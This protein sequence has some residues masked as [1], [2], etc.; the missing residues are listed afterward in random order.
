MADSKMKISIWSDV[1]CPFCYIG[2]RHYEAALAAFPD[3]DFIETEWHSYQLDP[4]LPTNH[5]ERLTT[6]EYLMQRKGIS[7]EQLSKMQGQVNAMAKAAG[8]D[9]T[10]ESAIIANTFQAHRI[11]QLAKQVGLGDA[12][13]EAFFKAH[14]IDG[15]DIGDTELL[16]NT[17]KSVGL[18]DAQITTALTDDQYAYLVRQDIQA[19]QQLGIRGVPFFVLDNKYGI[20]GA[21]PKEAILET[22]TKAYTEW[23]VHNPV[24][25]LETT[26]GPSCSADG[27]CE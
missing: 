23:R 20:S 13:E 14:F 25:T 22:L 17:A 5:E 10:T 26:Q 19:S 27:V 15:A 6:K 11:I 16:T 21:Q 9:F 1:M 12:I 24:T 7:E 3:K 18:T 2:K 8:L 4:T